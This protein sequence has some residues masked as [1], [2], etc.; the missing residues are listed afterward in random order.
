MKIVVMKRISLV[1]LFL[2]ALSLSESGYAQP[3]IYSRTRTLEKPQGEDVFVRFFGNNGDMLVYNREK[4]TNSE[5][6]TCRKSP[7]HPSANRYVIPS[8]NNTYG[9]VIYT[10]K[11]MVIVGNMCFF[12][13]RKTYITG[14]EFDMNG[15]PYPVSDSRGFVGQISLDNITD[16]QGSADHRMTELSNT[17]EVTR[18]DAKIDPNAPADTLLALVGETLNDGSCLVFSRVGSLQWDYRLVT[19]S[20]ATEWFTDV[21]FTGGNVVAAS[22]FE[23]EH[24]LF[25]LRGALLADV[26]NN[27]YTD[28]QTVY[29]FNTP[30]MQD[31]NL[32]INTTWHTDD[33]DIRLS[34]SSDNMVNVAY[35][36]FEE[37]PIGLQES[38]TTLFSMQVVVASD[39]QIIYLQNVRSGTKGPGALTDM[40]SMDELYGV[41]ILHRDMESQP[42]TSI[43]QMASWG[44]MGTLYSYAS[45]ADYEMTSLDKYDGKLLWAAGHQPNHQDSVVLFHQNLNYPTSGSCYTRPAYQRAELYYIEKSVAEQIEV[46]SDPEKADFKSWSKL[47]AQSTSIPQ[48]CLSGGFIV[49]DSETEPETE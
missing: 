27:V 45:G 32:G 41:A 20:D 49:I 8:E 1:V 24:Y 36:S 30:N 17:K 11:D 10:V 14:M 15:N 40:L 21:V 37:E 23:G 4:T 26:A 6:F 47:Y 38:F 35:E 18:I 22:R 28:L 48:R 42:P 25:G 46:I 29:T 44:V 5:V 34:A 3:S 9:G 7:S 13:G 19:S 16:A 12:C 43:V 2:F 31:Y 39:I 33:V